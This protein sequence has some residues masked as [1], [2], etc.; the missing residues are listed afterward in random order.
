MESEYHGITVVT[1]KIAWIQSLLT[2]LCLSPS[3]P[4][5]LWCDNQSVAH[6]AANPIFHAQAKQIELDLHFIRNKVLQNQLSIRYLLSFNQII[7]IFTKHISS[8]RFF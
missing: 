6:L 5:L 3:A 1:S 8:S 4:P 2:E 7:D